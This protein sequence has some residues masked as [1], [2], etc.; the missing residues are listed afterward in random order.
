[1]K[2]I[3]MFIVLA[4]LSLP[5]GGAVFAL[6]WTWLVVPLGAPPVGI[7]QAIG[8][9]LVLMLFKQPQQTPASEPDKSIL[10]EAMTATRWTAAVF[11]FGA[12]AHALG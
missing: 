10:G 5:L 7:A 3:A 9:V 8:L 12:C 1:M 6:L 2:S 4:A 11:V